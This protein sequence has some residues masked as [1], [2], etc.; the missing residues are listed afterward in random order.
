ME[1]SSKTVLT[2]RN[3]ARCAETHL[4]LAFV[5]FISR[6]RL[7][8]DDDQVVAEYTHWGTCPVRKEPILLLVSPD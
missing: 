6:M 1:D 2:V 7:Y 4:D 3:C 5:E 8:G